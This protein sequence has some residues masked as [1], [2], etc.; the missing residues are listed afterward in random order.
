MP[1]KTFFK[2][3]GAFHFGVNPP[4]VFESAEK[5]EV[6]SALKNL[7]DRK[8]WVCSACSD[9]HIGLKPPR[10][11]PTCNIVGKFKETSEKEFKMII[12]KF[13]E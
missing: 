10:E 6:E 7:K 11:C 5:P 9:L 2:K 8:L 4:P 1:Y 12:D 3:Q 13:L